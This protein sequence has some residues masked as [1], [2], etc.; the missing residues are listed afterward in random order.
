MG[1]A[2]FAV[3]ESGNDFCFW[4]ISRNFQERNYWPDSLF[5]RNPIQVCLLLIEQAIREGICADDVVKLSV[6]LNVIFFNHDI[7]PAHEVR[8]VLSSTFISDLCQQIGW[9]FFYVFRYPDNRVPVRFE[10]AD[11]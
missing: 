5:I 7:F 9:P 6:I 8:L 2:I 1:F 4:T 10:H 3:Y 11:Q